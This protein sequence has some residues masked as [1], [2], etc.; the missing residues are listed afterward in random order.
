[1]AENSSSGAIYMVSTTTRIDDPTWIHGQI[2]VGTKNSSIRVYCS[3]GINDG[4]ITHL[5][6][7]HACIKGYVEA[8][9]KVSP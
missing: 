8:C 2:V 5:K 7:Q 1:M 9:K 6:Y 4:G 3:K